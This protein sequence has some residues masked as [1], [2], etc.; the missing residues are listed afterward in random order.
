MKTLAILLLTTFSLAASAQTR[1]KTSSYQTDDV[2]QSVSDNGKT[3]HVTVK[4]N[5]NGNHV[6]YD[7][8]FEVIGMDQKHKDALLKRVNDSLG[9]K[10]PLAPPTDH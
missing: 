5:K 2:K 4:S 1:T 3:M 7:H 9:I 10:P 8:T 6:N